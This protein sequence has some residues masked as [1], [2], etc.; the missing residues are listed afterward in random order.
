[1]IVAGT[2][3]TVGSRAVSVARERPGPARQGQSRAPR[4][5]SSRPP[6]PHAIGWRSARRSPLTGSSSSTAQKPMQRTAC[7]RFRRAHH[8][9]KRQESQKT[10]AGFKIALSSSMRRTLALSA[11]ISASSSLVAPTPLP[12]V[13][14]GL[15]HPSADGL[16]TDTQLPGHH[17]R[18]RR[19][20]RSTRPSVIDQSYRSGHQLVVDLLRH[21]GCPPG[22]KQGAASNLGRFRLTVRFDPITQ[23]AH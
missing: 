19:S 3:R 7:S 9:R 16:L 13:D 11:L 21:D 5:L 1:M 15:D 6:T 17:R 10:V 2:V 8:P 4:R 22:L 12:A 14:L 18:S 23:P 20:A